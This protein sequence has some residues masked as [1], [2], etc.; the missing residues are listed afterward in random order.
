[1]KITVSDRNLNQ[2]TAI[3]PYLS[4]LA[5]PLCAELEAPA[6]LRVH[7]DHALGAHA[8][9]ALA[10]VVVGEDEAHLARALRE[11]LVAEVQRREVVLPQEERVASAVGLRRQRVHY[12]E[13]ALQYIDIGENQLQNAVNMNSMSLMSLTLWQGP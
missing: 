13:I 2:V 10:G 4:L 1:M 6:A 9:R 7:V 3:F 5:G 11:V 12:E 8:V